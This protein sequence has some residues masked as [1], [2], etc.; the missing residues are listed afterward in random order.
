MWYIIRTV[1]EGY[2]MME[3]AARNTKYGISYII[4]ILKLHIKMTMMGRWR[5]KSKT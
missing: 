1:E 4:I 2:N 5:K 3:K